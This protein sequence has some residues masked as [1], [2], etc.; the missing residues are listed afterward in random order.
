MNFRNF[1]NANFFFLFRFI[2]KIVTDSSVQLD[3]AMMFLISKY[4]NVYFSIRKNLPTG[5]LE[6]Q[7]E[8]KHFSKKV[9][10]LIE[11]PLIHVDVFHDDL[12]ATGMDYDQYQVKILHNEQ[13]KKIMS[14]T[15]IEPETVDFPVISEPRDTDSNPPISESESEIDE[16]LS[17]HE[18]ANYSYPGNAFYSNSQNSVAEHYPQNS[19]PPISDDSQCDDNDTNSNVC[20]NLRQLNRCFSDSRTFQKVGIHNKKR[21]WWS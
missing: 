21:N 18:F 4:Y 1:V 17:P 7:T 13:E 11:I 9:D 10:D 15:N 12:Y 5:D 8:V 16:N 2:P 14:E 20:A 19:T 6:L 3:H